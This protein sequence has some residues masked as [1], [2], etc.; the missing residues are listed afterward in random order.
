MKS[1]EKRLLIELSEEESQKYYEFVG[2]CIEVEAAAGVDPIGYSSPKLCIEFAGPFGEY[3]T[4]K[5]HG[6]EIVLRDL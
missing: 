6:K 4:V 1:S 2:K 5:M 3:I